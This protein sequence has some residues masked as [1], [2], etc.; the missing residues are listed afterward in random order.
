MDTIQKDDYI[1]FTVIAGENDQYSNTIKSTAE[2]LNVIGY[3][4]SNL[5]YIGEEAALEEFV[6]NCHDD[7]MGSYGSYDEFAET[8]YSKT[9]LT[10][11]DGTVINA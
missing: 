2:E 7:F 9:K 8:N 1:E 3:K 6:S 10:R 5:E 11:K 4:T